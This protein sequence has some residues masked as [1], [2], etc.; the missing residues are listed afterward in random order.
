MLSVVTSNLGKL[1]EFRSALKPMGVEVQHSEEDCDEIQADDLEEVVLPC[2]TQLRRRGLENFIVDDSGLFIHTL[3]GFPGVYSAYAFKTIGNQ[4]LLR[5]LEESD[6]RSAHFECC[7]GCS[8]KGEDYLIVKER[9]DGRII[10][11]MRGK[12][13]F[14]FDPVFVPEGHDQTF[15]EMPLE[16]KNKISHRGKAIGSFVKEL[17][18]RMESGR[19]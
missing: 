5:L 16:F 14:G 15:A 12:E 8:L 6:D 1:Q 19:K 7:I 9:C 17:N 3:K 4:G 11:E 2:L 18:T 13:G 10:R